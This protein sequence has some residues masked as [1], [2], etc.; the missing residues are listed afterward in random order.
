M[1]QEKKAIKTVIF[2]CGRVITFDQNLQ[3]A[4]K[5]GQLVGAAPDAFDAV[6]K[7]ERTEYDR[8]T[9]SATEY[10]NKVARH[11]GLTLDAALVAELIELDM[12]SWF[13]INP[14]T[15]AIIQELKSL[16]YRLLILSNMNVEGKS[17]MFGA[18]RF[19]GA[20]DWIGL[21]DDVVLSCDLAL[22]K[23]EPA[24]Y[25]SCLERALASPRECVFIDDTPANVVAARECGMHGVVF[26]HAGHLRLVL[27]SEYRVL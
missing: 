20:V 18:S 2:D 9:L 22:L 10:W 16:G 25:H 5:M 19:C 7:A 15:V 4:E 23:P 12:D 13:T 6:Y 27:K 17:R 14:E 8:G 11:F 3:I 1:K 26:S 24:I 21:F